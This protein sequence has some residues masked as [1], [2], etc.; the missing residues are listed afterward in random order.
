MFCLFDRLIL[1]CSVDNEKIPEMDSDSEIDLSVTNPASF[2][3]ASPEVNPEADV[4]EDEELIESELDLSLPDPAAYIC[5]STE[6][7]PEVDLVESEELIGEFPS[8]GIDDFSLPLNISAPKT[9]TFVA[10][11]F[12]YHNYPLVTIQL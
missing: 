10:K 12:R 3:P 7:Y 2:K 8:E 9:K 11:N 5:A 4:V 6:V 1:F